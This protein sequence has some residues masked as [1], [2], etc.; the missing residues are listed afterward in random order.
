MGTA[1]GRMR[2]RTGSERR[3]EAEPSGKGRETNGEKTPNVAQITRNRAVF[4]ETTRF[5]ETITRIRSRF[6]RRRLRRKRGAP[7]ESP[8]EAALRVRAASRRRKT[9]G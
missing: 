3:D 5:F 6:L 8:N 1:G 9:L 2:K 7:P 4:D